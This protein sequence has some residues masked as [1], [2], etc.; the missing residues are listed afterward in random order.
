MHGDSVAHRLPP[1]SLRCRQPS[2]ARRSSQAPAQRCNR[3]EGIGNTP[4][5]HGFPCFDRPH[6]EL[7]CPTL[8][9]TGALLLANQH[10]VKLAD[11]SPATVCPT[12][13]E[14]GTAVGT[15]KPLSLPQSSP[16]PRHLNLAW[17]VHVASLMP[18]EVEPKNPGHRRMA[19]ACSRMANTPARL[20]WSVT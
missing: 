17:P 11:S 19:G 8:F 6:D 4:P 18:R 2:S 12:A 7:T 10:M 16:A 14:N 13:G 3:R 1:F 9:R 20:A 5:H 15:F